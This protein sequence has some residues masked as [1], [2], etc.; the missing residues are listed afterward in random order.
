LILEQPTTVARMKAPAQK[1][2]TSQ[3]DARM[4][5]RGP[6][7]RFGARL[8]S[9]SHTLVSSGGLASLL[10]A[11]TTAGCTAS[12]SREQTERALLQSLGFQRVVVEWKG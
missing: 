8:G 4:L 11:A 9:I 10:V 12:S 3:L 1:P 2:V 6:S 5:P 7:C